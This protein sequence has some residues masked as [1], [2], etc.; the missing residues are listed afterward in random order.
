MNSKL[1]VLTIT[2]GAL[3]VSGCG[4]GHRHGQHQ[5]SVK[6]INRKL[7]VLFDYLDATADQRA[8]I[9]RQLAG[10]ASEAASL[11]QAH[12]R[13]RAELLALWR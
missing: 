6:E 2:C 3:A 11:H 9:Q 7:E 4:H 10:V 12:R 5:L 1:L 8:Q 13:E